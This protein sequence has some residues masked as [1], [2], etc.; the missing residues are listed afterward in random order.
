VAPPTSVTVLAELAELVA[1]RARA[2]DSVRIVVERLGQLYGASSGAL[3][4]VS[5]PTFA[6]I[7]AAVGEAS[8]LA[9]AV[10]APSPLLG[11]AVR[12]TAVEQLTASDCAD[13]LGDL[14]DLPDGIVVCI[15]LP[16]VTGSAARGALI[17]GGLEADTERRLQLEPVARAVAALVVLALPQADGGATAGSAGE[18]AARP[19]RRLERIDV[20]LARATVAID[21]YRE[22]FDSASDGIVVT[23]AKGVVLHLNRAARQLTGYASEGLRGRRLEDIVDEQDRPLLRAAVGRSLQSSA[24]GRAAGRSAE[25]R[26]PFDLSITTTSGD[27]LRASFSTSAA[28]AE[29]GCAVL[30]FRDVTERR[31]LE[32]ELRRT[33]DFLERLIQSTVDGIVAADLS[34]LIVLFNVGAERISGWRADEVIGKLFVSDLYPEGEATAV[35][36]LLRS[37][38][39]GGSGK[40]EQL[41]REIVRKDGERVPVSL[42]A[43]V[44]YDGE[45]EVATVGVFTDLRERL[46]IEER[47]IAAQQRLMVTE[48]QALLAELA[49]AAAHELNQPLTSILGCAEL[50]QRRMGSDNPAWRLVEIVSQ[51]AERMATVVRRIGRITQ[52]ETKPYVGTTQILDLEKSGAPGEGAQELGRT[53]SGEGSSR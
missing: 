33:K 30:A 46:R 21:R 35:M 32:E 22:F 20:A 17:Y 44:V 8:D 27:L 5:D 42:S 48:K 47:L 12:Q 45:V 11:E 40:L 50:A 36:Q 38:Q 25:E 6:Q 15:P 10:V 43:A 14:P 49:G 23:D 31:A 9:G 13:V 16:T 7:L 3:L 39:Q 34:G 4:G 26:A 53:S 2:P 18:P 51:E 52:Y 19:T 24:A 41:R 1:T 37:G 29:A 28:L